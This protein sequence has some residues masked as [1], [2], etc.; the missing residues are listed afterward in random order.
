[1]NN[2]KKLHAIYVL[3]P[4]IENGFGTPRQPA[5]LLTKDCYF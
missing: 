5:P 1:M 3:Q 4:V 2:D